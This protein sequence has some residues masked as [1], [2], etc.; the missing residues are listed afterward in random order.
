M[1]QLCLGLAR[2]DFVQNSQ[3]KGGDADGRLCPQTSRIRFKALSGGS[4]KHRPSEARFVRVRK[5]AV[6]TRFV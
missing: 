2:R 6:D 4:D 5:V 3:G 1:S